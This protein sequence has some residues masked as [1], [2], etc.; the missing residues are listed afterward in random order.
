MQS[1]WMPEKVLGHAQTGAVDNVTPV[2]LSSLIFQGQ[3]AARIP[4]GTVLLLIQPNA[5]TAAIRWRDDGTAPTA[6]VGYPLAAGAELRYTAQGF[7]AIQVIGQTSGAVVNV[8]AY[9]NS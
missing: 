2:L 4:P 6:S 8:V 7:A 3:P 1:G 9:G 5:A